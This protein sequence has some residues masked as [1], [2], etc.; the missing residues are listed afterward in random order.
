M[1]VG[2]PGWEAREGMGHEGCTVL[3]RSSE[4]LKGSGSVA[5]REEH[6]HLSFSGP[7][8]CQ[9]FCLPGRAGLALTSHK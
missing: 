4:P 8:V 1:M 5:E 9:L 7:D 6:L 3:P 2:F